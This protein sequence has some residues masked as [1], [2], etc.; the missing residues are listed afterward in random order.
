MSILME[1]PELM[2]EALAIMVRRAGGSVEIGT[3]ESFAIPFNLLS[4]WDENGLR[5]V[6][7]EGPDAHSLFAPRE[8]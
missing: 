2:L 1:R 3:D 7:E 4:K 8:H 5:L 6:L